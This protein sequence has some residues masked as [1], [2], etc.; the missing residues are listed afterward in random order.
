MLTLTENAAKAVEEIVAAD[1]EVAEDAGVRIYA[2]PREDGG[3]TLGVAVAETPQEDDQVIE[4]AGAR[5]FVE[6]T[7]VG[8]VDSKTLDAVADEKGTHFTLS[9]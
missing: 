5:V 7:I 9:E 4:E 1:P 6:S 8:L 2:M 3:T